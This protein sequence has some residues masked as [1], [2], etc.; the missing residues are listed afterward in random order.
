MAL[1][2]GT[3]CGFV[4]IAPT[5]DPEGSGTDTVDF[6]QFASRFT[7]PATATTVT[8]IGWYCQNATEAGDFEVGIYT[9]SANNPVDLVGSIGGPSAKGTDL[10]W[11]VITGLNIS[12]SAETIYWIGIACDNTTTATKCDYRAITG[13]RQCF[14][15]NSENL[16]D[17]WGENTQNFASYANAIYA[18]WE[19]GADPTTS[20]N[21]GDSWKSIAGMQIN[22]GDSWKAIA[23]GAINIGDAWKHF[24]I[25]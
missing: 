11:K 8:E 22:I 2:D 10:G 20:I 12:I 24:D 4:T 9:E 21:I 16:T 6:M 18:V 23:S 14:K 19:A 13:L 7:T 15:W 17:P 3:N 5:T 1:V 25:S